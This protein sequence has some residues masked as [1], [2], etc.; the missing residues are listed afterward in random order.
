MAYTIRLAAPADE[1]FLW[2]MLFYAANM[3]DDGAASG[4]EARA[5]PYLAKYVRG[6]GRPGDLG[7]LALE[8]AG[9]RP[10]GAA[11]VRLLEGA[12]KNYPSVAA[13]IPELA[14]AVLPDLVGQGIGGRLL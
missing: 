14:I 2:Q 9:E 13:G 5:H 1:P 11:W 6:W 12:E 4:E 8:R 7:T 3:A 10:V